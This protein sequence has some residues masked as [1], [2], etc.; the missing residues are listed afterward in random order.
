MRGWT[1]WE[2]DLGAKESEVGDRQRLRIA[3]G[4]NEKERKSGEE[5]TIIDAWVAFH[6]ANYENERA[7]ERRKDGEWDDC[8]RL[9]KF[10][11]IF[12]MEKYHFVFDWVV[13]HILLWKKM[14]HFHISKI[15]YLYFYKRDLSKLIF[16]GT[17]N[18][19]LEYGLQ[20]GCNAM[21]LLAVWGEVE[22]N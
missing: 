3:R 12:L 15:L 22:R 6:C 17:N 5:V 2:A 10:P 13:F 1:A 20:I 4:K 21:S 9:W 8:I 16:Y 19:D 11:Y 7:M 18:L 14:V